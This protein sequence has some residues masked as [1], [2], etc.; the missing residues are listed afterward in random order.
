GPLE[1]PSKNSCGACFLFLPLRLN[2]RREDLQGGIR[3]P[4]I[5]PTS[6]H[7]PIHLPVPPTQTLLQ[8]GLGGAIGC[9]FGTAHSELVFVEYNTTGRLL[10]INI[11]TCA[12]TVITSARAEPIGLVLSS[13]LQYAYV[14]EQSG[15]ISKVQIS[16]ATR[17]T[18]ATGLTSPFFLT[19]AD[20]AQDS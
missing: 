5:T 12:K 7:I 18:L 1:P 13:D 15:R 14:S 10:K 4:A 19:W 11:T 17:T 6:I 16:S 8:A 9:D 20:A 2:P 3:M